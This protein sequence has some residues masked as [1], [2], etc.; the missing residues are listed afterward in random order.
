VAIGLNRNTARRKGLALT[1]FCD[2]AWRIPGSRIVNLPER[3]GK[4][5]WRHLLTCDRGATSSR[6]GRGEACR[7]G[8][9]RGTAAGQKSSGATPGSRDLF[10][11]RRLRFLIKAI[12]CRRVLTV[13]IP[14]V[15]AGLASVWIAGWF[16]LRVSS[17]CTSKAHQLTLRVV[18][19]GREHGPVPSHSRPGLSDSKAEFEQLP[20]MRPR[21]PRAGFGFL[22]ADDPD[23]YRRATAPLSFGGENR[24][25]ALISRRAEGRRA[26][27]GPLGLKMA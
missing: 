13:F 8:C 17:S 19:A 14:M 26:A 5:G 25:G 20:R 23:A 27:R 4:I 1:S 15:R 16:F 12:I 11:R 24:K 21:R 18:G 3:F 6:A 10:R 7:F 9:R 2:R 22:C